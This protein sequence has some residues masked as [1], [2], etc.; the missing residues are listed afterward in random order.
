MQLGRQV[1]VRAGSGAAAPNTTA[2]AGTLA[3]NAGV[4]ARIQLPEGL[5]AGRVANFVIRAIEFTSV[6]ANL[7]D[8]WF[9][10]NK[11]FQTG[12]D[13]TP[14]SFRGLYSFAAAGK[15]IGAT[16]LYYGYVDGLGIF[17]EDE[18]AGLTQNVVTKQG[19]FLNV[20]LINR[21]AGAKSAGWFDVAFHCEPL[22]G[23]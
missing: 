20:T 9:W 3:Q 11:N 5:A 21:S 19:A 16:G 13:A 18:D 6:D 22:Q 17:Y 8:F 23:W 2:F 15:Q 7:W 14:E 12:V 1:R 4:N 10:G